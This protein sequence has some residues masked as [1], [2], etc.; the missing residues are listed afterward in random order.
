MWVLMAVT[1]AVTVPFVCATVVMAELAVVVVPAL[2]PVP[3][4]AT[5][6]VL[7][8]LLFMAAVGLHILFLWMGL[9]FEAAVVNNRFSDNRE[10][11]KSSDG[12]RKRINSVLATVLNL[13]DCAVFASLC[14]SGRD[15]RDRK[16][17]GDYC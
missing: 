10:S 1:I 13:W 11:D 2:C 15:S 16:S 7:R 4:L 3:I 12:G 17:G 5:M 14:H 6:V 9:L 8:A